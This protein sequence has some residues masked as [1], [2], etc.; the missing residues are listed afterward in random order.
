MQWGFADGDA[1]TSSAFLADVLL[2]R[3]DVA[4]ARAALDRAADP[5]DR[6]DGARYWLNARLELLVAEGRA[7]DAVAAADDFARRY[8]HYRNP[9]YAPLA[10]LQGA[11]A[12][13]LDSATRRSRSP[14]R[15]SSARGTGARPGARRHVAADPRHAQA[16]R[17]ACDELEEAV[18]VLEGSPA[19]LELAK[20]LAALGPRCAARGSPPRRASRCAAR[21]S[22]RACCAATGLVEHARG[23]LHATGARPRTRCRERRRAR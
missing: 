20:A 21:S 1:R 12:R 19:R 4:G 2:E 18:E 9:A 7:E 10:H 13:R 6:S 16:R 8:P 14:R 23:E 15:S 11:G 5:G 17:R 22:W 3:G